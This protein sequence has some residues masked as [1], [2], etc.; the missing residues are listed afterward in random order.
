MLRALGIERWDVA[1][2]LNPPASPIVQVS[3]RQLGIG[4]GDRFALINPGA[5]WPNKRWPTARFGEVAIALNDRHGIRSLVLWGPGEEAMAQEVASASGG[6]AG[7]S[8]RTT[9]SELLMLARSAALVVSGDTGPLHLAAAVGTPVVGIYGPTQPERN[10]PWAPDDVTVSRYSSC[11]CHHRR[12]CHAERWCLLDV[13]AADVIEL[14]DV[15]LARLAA[16]D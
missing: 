16:R 6:A 7:I 8:P 15:R 11:Q 4:E 12:R 5:G 9:V 10:G 13:T 1:F 2:P 14:V 3:R